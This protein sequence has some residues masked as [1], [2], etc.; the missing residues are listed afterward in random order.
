MNALDSCC[1][2]RATPSTHARV[3]ARAIATIVLA[4]LF[5]AVAAVQAKPPT[6]VAAG[7]TPHSSRDATNATGTTWFISPAGNDSKPG[8]SAETAMK[9]FARAFSRMA[10][11]DELVLLNGTYSVENGTGIIHYQGNK[12]AQPPSGKSPTQRTVIRADQPGSAIVKGTLFLGRSA[13]KDSY[14]RIQGIT[15]DGGGSL[16]NTSYVYIKDC[17][18]HGSFGIGTNDHHEGNSYNLIEDVWIWASGQRIIA[19]NYRSHFNVWRRVLVRGDGCGQRECQGSGN[20]NVGIT[21]YDSNNVSFQNVMVVD[22]LLLAGDSPYADFA[23]AQHTPEPRYYLGKNEWLGTISLNSPDNGYYMEPDRG[24]TLDPTIKISNAIAWNSA[25]SGFNL[26]REGT[27]DLLE[28]LTASAG[29]DGIRVAPALADKSGQ[30]RNSL[31]VRAGRFGVNSAFP[32]SYMSIYGSTDQAVNRKQAPCE[33]S[34]FFTNPRSDG[35]PPSL[36]FLLRVEEGSFLS[37]RGEN[38]KPIGAVIMRRYG[39]DGAYF[40]EA[41]YNTLTPDP[42][43]PWANEERIKREMCADTRRGFCA[44][45]SLTHYLWSQLGNEPNAA[46]YQTNSGV[47]KR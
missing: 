22:R 4:L 23:V 26:D 42:L 19:I 1:P 38:G 25:G 43:W 27:H 12:A 7:V 8:R 11:G 15:F 37:A 39:R 28:N 16:F 3:V 10:A 36:R 30:L 33:R 32:S 13:R 5:P 21:V 34:C 2:E 24:Q 29:G 14:L 40:N 6:S 44:S 17:G 18:F 35:Q 20:P 47:Q 45:Q 46:L 41:G 31:V 9:S